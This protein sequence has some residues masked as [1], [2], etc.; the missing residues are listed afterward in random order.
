MPCVVDS[1]AVRGEGFEDL[2]GGLGPDEWPGTLVPLIRRTPTDP[3]T[4]VTAPTHI[5]AQQA[6]PTPYQGVFAVL[7]D[8][9]Y[10]YIAA[11]ISGGSVQSAESG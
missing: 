11:L 6:R 3:D 9:R 1:L 4:A 7:S 10:R 2:V 5:C 8:I